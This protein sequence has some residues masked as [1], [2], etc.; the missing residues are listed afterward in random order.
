MKTKKLEKCVN[1]QKNSILKILNKMTKLCRSTRSENPAIC[2]KIINIEVDLINA[3]NELRG[4]TNDLFTLIKNAVNEKQDTVTI[5][6][7]E[8][9]KYVSKLVAII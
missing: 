8:M 5:S 7:T 1:Y 3:H 6:V 4:V 2:K 9:Q